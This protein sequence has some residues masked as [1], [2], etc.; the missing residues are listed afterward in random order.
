MTESQR[1]RL[2]GYMACMGETGSAQLESHKEKI[3]LNK[4]RHRWE[5]IIKIYLQK[6]FRPA[7]QLS[8]SKDTAPQSYFTLQHNYCITLHNSYVLFSKFVIQK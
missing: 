5:D 8:A 7:E 1:M 6:N 3:P 2:A 4:V